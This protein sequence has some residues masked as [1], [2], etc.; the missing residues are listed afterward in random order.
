ML[1]YSSATWKH[2]IFWTAWQLPKAKKL[3][4]THLVSFLFVFFSLPFEN[5]FDLKNQFKRWHKEAGTLSLSVSLSH[6]AFVPK[7]SHASLA[8]E[9]STVHSQCLR[10][11]WDGSYSWLLLNVRRWVTRQCVGSIFY[12][13]TCHAINEQGSL[14]GTWKGQH[15]CLL[16]LASGYPHWVTLL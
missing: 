11:G 15:T 7:I 10:A 1:L 12:T 6:C 2:W 5:L 9:S 4:A 13:A 8:L 14:N 16:C 3:L